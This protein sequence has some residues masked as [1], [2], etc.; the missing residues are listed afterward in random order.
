M[1]YFRFRQK[2]PDVQLESRIV[3]IERDDFILL[4]T[5]AYLGIF[6]GMDDDS[7]PTSRSW[8]AGAFNVL[9]SY[10]KSAIFVFSAQQKFSENEC[11]VEKL[12]GKKGIFVKFAHF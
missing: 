6:K 3:L 9:F 8:G 10:I 4:F 12:I 2:S 5:K 1:P 11:T 7:F